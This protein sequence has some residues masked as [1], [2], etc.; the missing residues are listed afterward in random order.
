MNVDY[1]LELLG[2]ACWKAKLNPI[3]ADEIIEFAKEQLGE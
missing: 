1:F 2:D 3:I